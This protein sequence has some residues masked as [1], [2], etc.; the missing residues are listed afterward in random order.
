MHEGQPI[1]IPYDFRFSLCD[2]AVDGSQIGG[3]IVE[4]DVPISD[5]LFTVVLDL[6]SSAFDGGAR[7]LEIGVRPGDSTGAHIV[8]T[9]RRHITP[10]PYA[11]FAHNADR[12]DGRD[13]SS[14]ASATHDHDGRYYRNQSRTQFTGTL[15]AGQTRTYFTFNWPTDEIVY[16][17]MHPT[18]TD[19]RVDWTVGIR[20][21]DNGRFIYYLTVTNTGSKTTAFAAKYVVFR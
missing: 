5:G 19:G 21:V 18:T 12:L 14:Y 20:L 1:E 2:A 11:S 4:E 10:T 8:L 17:T 7:Y 9:P 3:E 13:S 15:N 16:W 6:G